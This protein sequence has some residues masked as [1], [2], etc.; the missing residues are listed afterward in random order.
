VAP[1]RTLAVTASALAVTRA[2]SDGAWAA[3]SGGEGAVVG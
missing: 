1:L 2:A 3:T